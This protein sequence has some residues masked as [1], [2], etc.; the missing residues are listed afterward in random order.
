MWNRYLTVEEFEKLVRPKK[1]LLHQE[2]FGNWTEEPVND[3]PE[4]EPVM[5]RAQKESMKKPVRWLSD[6]IPD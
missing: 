6:F 5:V 3:T 1:R 4:K 2:M